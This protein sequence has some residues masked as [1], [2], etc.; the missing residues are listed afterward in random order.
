MT[1]VNEEVNA[2]EEPRYKL[3]YHEYGAVRTT[4]LLQTN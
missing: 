2:L 3:E 4:G 1:S